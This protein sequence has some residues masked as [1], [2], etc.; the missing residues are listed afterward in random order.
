MSIGALDA[1][2]AYGRALGVGAGKT[3]GG[4]PTP[5]AET[6]KSGNFGAMV[7]N[8]VT[9]TADSLRAAEHASAM[10]VAGKGDLIDVVTAIGAAE[11]ALDTMVAVRDRVVNAYTDIMRMQI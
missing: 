2:S 7:E 6:G 11:T 1:A 10:Q 4:A 5:A 3:P 8:M 9:E